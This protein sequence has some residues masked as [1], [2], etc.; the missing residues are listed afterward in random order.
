VNALAQVP[1]AFAGTPE[2]AVASLRALIQAGARIDCVLTQP[3]RPAGRGRQLK[4]SPVKALA[5]LH[6]IAVLQ[7]ERLDSHARAA[8]PEQRPKLF[9]VAAYGLILPP[10]LLDWPETAAVNVHASLLPRWRG[11]SP[12]QQA[13]LAGDAETGVSI[14]RMTRGLDEGPVYSRR[15]TR[16]AA[17]ETAGEL[18]DRLA[19]LGARV[20][21][22][23][24]PAILAGSLTPKPQDSSRASFA[25][26]I[27]KSDALLDWTRTALELE[28]DVRAY[29]PWPVAE[30]R[31]DSG[32]RLRIWRAAARSGPGTAV[33]GTVLAAHADGID[34]ATADGV[35]RLTSLQSPGGRAMSAAAWLAG[36]ST[37][38]L[39]FVA[40]R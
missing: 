39:R 23:T 6:D 40:A 36:R 37:Q 13:I 2:F 32:E 15:A 9:V 24:L 31:T 26:R 12:I 3:D 17:G 4:A 25:R 14:M 10:W 27:A 11:A 5:L 19:A 18:H 30:A 22:E 1:L 35:L 21:V 16:I 8:L 7:P 28:R 33:P 34:V 29:N 20:L 38:G